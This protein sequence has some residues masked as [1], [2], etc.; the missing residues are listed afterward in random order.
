M[1]GSGSEAADSQGAAL[2]NKC[3]GFKSGSDMST[4]FIYRTVEDAGGVP[5]TSADRYG[6]TLGYTVPREMASSIVNTLAIDCSFEPWDVRDAIKLASIESEEAGNSAQI[7]LTENLY[8]AA[9]GAQTAAGRTF[10]S[11]DVTS[12]SVKDFRDQGYGIKGAVLAATGIPDHAAFCSEVSELLASAPAGDSSKA[13]PFSYL[14]G[15]SRV[16]APGSGYAHVALAFQSSATSVVASVVKHALTLAV[17]ESGLQ[18]FSSKGL[19]GV[20]AGSA[21]SAGI[22]DAMTTALTSS[23]TSDV[24]ARAKALAKLETLMAIDGGSKTLAEVMTASVLETGSF[25][26]PA[27]IAKS[28]DTVTDG[29]VTSALSAMLK[30]NP[31]L[32][33]VGDISMVPVSSSSLFCSVHIQ[34]LTVYLCV[35]LSSTMPLSQLVSVSF[36]LLSN[37]NEGD[38][39]VPQIVVF[40]DY[41]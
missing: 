3:L 7:V 17:S 8:A 32:A 14:G 19:V 26:G 10:Y 33:A 37:K 18:G 5:F 22:V 23:L 21:D 4:L 36:V 24:I 13:A 12:D 11:Y 41:F 9:Y 16:Y 15:E 1:A 38:S 2:V 34:R 35:A 28:Y 39:L 31:S 25:S 20:Y 29:D 40:S 27:D 30:S 6:A